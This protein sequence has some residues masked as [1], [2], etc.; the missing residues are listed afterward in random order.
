M[1]HE[2]TGLPLSAAIVLAATLAVGAADPG[3][4]F[5]GE[6]PETKSVRTAQT[7]PNPAPKKPTEKKAA[8]AAIYP[9]VD[10]PSGRSVLLDVGVPPV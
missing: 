5:A 4:T 2:R 8:P 6:T 10:R 7:V 1:T 3:E 9:R